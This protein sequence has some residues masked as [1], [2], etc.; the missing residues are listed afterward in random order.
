MTKLDT[1]KCSREH[2]E[3]PLRVSCGMRWGQSLPVQC[4]AQNR[5]PIF[6]TH[7]QMPHRPSARPES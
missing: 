2:N 5:A 1:V 3:M 7:Q 4:Q 6:C